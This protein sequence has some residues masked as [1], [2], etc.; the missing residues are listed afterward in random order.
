VMKRASAGEGWYADLWLI[1]QEGAVHHRDA[2]FI[3]SFSK[4]VQG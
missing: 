3:E 2:G 4:P 1:L